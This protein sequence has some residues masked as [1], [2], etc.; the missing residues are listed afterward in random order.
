MEKH[1]EELAKRLLRE[2]VEFKKAYK[3]HKSYEENIAKLDKKKQLKPEDEVEINRLKKLKLALKDGMEK[4]L[5]SYRA[6]IG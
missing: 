5:A 2:D 3:A 6:K 1:D 4:K